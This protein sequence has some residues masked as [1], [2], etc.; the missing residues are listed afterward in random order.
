MQR[1]EALL[2]TDAGDVLAN[3]SL[4]QV[5]KQHITSHNNRCVKNKTGKYS[6]FCAGSVFAKTNTVFF[7]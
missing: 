3:Q 5:C 1:L 7:P 2:Y 6:H 4:Q